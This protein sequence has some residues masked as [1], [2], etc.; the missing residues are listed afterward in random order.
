MRSTE[1]VETVREVTPEALVWLFAVLTNLGSPL[2]LVILVAILYWTLDRER[3]AF[4]LGV[5]IGG[6]ALTVALKNVFALPRP[7][8][9]LHLVAQEGYG[10]PSGHAVGSTVVYGT[11]AV[12]LDR[13]ERR[14]RYVAAAVLVAVVAVSRVV[15][16]VHYP[17]DVLAGVLI[18]V[19]YLAVAFAVTRHD[20]MRA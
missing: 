9:G 19:V 12:V 18:G 15:T 8:S 3:G 14:D 7:P 6:L 4:V 2:F 16:G 17:A 1:A 10:F 20:G 13:W 11:L 5:A